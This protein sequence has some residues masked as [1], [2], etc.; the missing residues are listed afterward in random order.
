LRS[1]RLY[2]LMLAP[3]R[4]VGVAGGG[5]NPSLPLLELCLGTSPIQAEK[6][7]PDRNVFRIRHAGNESGRLASLFGRGC[8]IDRARLLRHQAEPQRP[9]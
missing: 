9:E 1:E 4:F 8:T 3:K 2:G 7:R 6:S 5:P